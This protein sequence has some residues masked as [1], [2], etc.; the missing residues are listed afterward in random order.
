MSCEGNVRDFNEINFLEDNSAKNPKKKE[1]TSFKKQSNY[2]EDHNYGSANYNNHGNYKKK[3]GFAKS[4]KEYNVE[5]V[6]K[7]I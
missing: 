1:K 5:Y 4:K 7:N 3:G 2:N 6:P